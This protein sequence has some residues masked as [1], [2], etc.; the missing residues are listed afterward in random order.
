MKIAKDLRVYK[1]LCAEFLG[2]VYLSLKGYKILKWNYK[3]KATAQIDIVAEKQGVVRLV[4]VKFRKRHID[5]VDAISYHQKKRLMFSAQSMSSK[6]KKDVVV[7]GLYFS[8]DKPYICHKK[9]IF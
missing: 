2:C 9:N 7:D 4:E 8:L 6:Y 3:I 5:A 1:G